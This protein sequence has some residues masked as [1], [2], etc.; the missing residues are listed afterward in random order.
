MQLKHKNSP[1]IF[2]ET[3]PDPRLRLSQLRVAKAAYDELAISGPRLPLRHTPIPAILALRKIR[4][5]IAESE[6]L[7]TTTRERLLE[8]RDRLS[9]DTKNLRDS[10][11]ISDA[12]EK[13]IAKFHLRVAERSRRSPHETTKA[14]MDERGERTSTYQKNTKT[15]VRSLVRFINLHVGPMLAAEKHVPLTVRNH[16]SLTEAVLTTGFNQ[17]SKASGLEIQPVLVDNEEHGSIDEDV[18]RQVAGGCDGST[19]RIKRHEIE[20][21]S[22]ELRVLI[23]N[24]LNTVVEEGSEAYV[25]VQQDMAAAQFLIRAKAAQIHP[26]NARKVRLVDFERALPEKCHANFVE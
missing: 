8:A 26:G 3:S 14:M 12:L 25:T 24:L 10:R 23:E 15:L 13:R 7:I 16:P 21:A 1:S 19:H 9:N 2:D 4:L 20:S 6:E 18:K 17:R 11:L 22:A 5:L